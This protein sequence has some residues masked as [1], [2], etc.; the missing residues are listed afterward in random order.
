MSFAFSPNIAVTD[1]MICGGGNM[2]SGCQ[3]DSG[4]PFV[5]PN[6]VGRYIVQGVVSWGHPL[7]ATYPYYSVFAK[8][9]EYT[10]WI[11]SKIYSSYVTQQNA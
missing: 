7:C 4:G 5:C 1:K 8:V 6:N 3:G 2:K 10:D 9:S 11:E